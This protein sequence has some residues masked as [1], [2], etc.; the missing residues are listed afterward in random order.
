MSNHKPTL[1]Y[2]FYFQ[3]S[4]S[5]TVCRCTNFVNEHGYGQC[6][7]EDEDFGDTVMCYVVQPS[8]CTDVTT[9]TTNVD[10]LRSAEACLTGNEIV[11]WHFLK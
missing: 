10:Q 8:S 4:M 2:M 11:F 5:F 6:L 9:S 3:C 1:R 7:K